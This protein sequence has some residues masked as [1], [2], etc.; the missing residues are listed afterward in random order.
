VA[1]GTILKVGENLVVV[2]E[3]MKNRKIDADALKNDLAGAGIPFDTL[4]ILKAIPRDP[5]HHS[6]ID[7]DR[8]REGIQAK[9]IVSR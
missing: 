8:L 2:V 4:Q 5:R 9:F 6:K 3:A 1:T 7:Y